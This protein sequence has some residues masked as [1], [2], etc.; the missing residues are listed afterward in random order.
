MAVSMRFLLWLVLGCSFVWGQTPP[1]FAIQADYIRVPV[2]VFDSN[3]QLSSL[4]T[5]KDFVIFDEGKQRPIVNFVLDKSPLHIVLLLDVSGS[6][7]EEIEEFKDASLSFAKA[8]GKEDRIAVVSFSDEPQLLQDWTNKINRL[9]KALNKLEPG[10]RTALYDSLLFTI[11]EKLSRV[12]HK[13]VIILLTDGLDNESQAGFDEILNLLVENDISLYIVS[14]TRLVQPQIEESRRV[15]FLNKVMKNV[16]NDDENFVD[17]YFREKETAMRHLAESSGGRVLFP[18]K[19]EELTGTYRQVAE[20][21]KTQY[22]LTFRPPAES[23]LKFRS[24]R[25]ECL[26]PVRKLYYRQQYYWDAARGGRT[27]KD[28]KD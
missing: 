14:R 17:V 18:T 28:G 5:Q 11:K 15:Q 26:K 25:V 10:Y 13:R 1:R 19:L 6:L 2:T 24:I 20:E 12:P 16:L 9:R 23:D 8:F 7:E 27:G 21:L 3:N 4:L 22:V